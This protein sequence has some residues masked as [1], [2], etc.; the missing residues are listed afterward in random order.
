M[1]FKEWLINE[2]KQKPLAIIIKGNPNRKQPHKPGNLYPKLKQYLQD[3]GFQVEF[4][5]GK[6]HTTPNL[7]AAM[8]YW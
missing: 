7:K 1:N 4:D 3:K 5:E 2:Q 8:L 6:P